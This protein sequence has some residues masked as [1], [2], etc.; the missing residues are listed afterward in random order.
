MALTVAGKV[1]AGEKTTIE[2]RRLGRGQ[3]RGKRTI[4]SSC[5]RE[6]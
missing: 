1:L 4:Y 2:V 6:N 3:L 5:L